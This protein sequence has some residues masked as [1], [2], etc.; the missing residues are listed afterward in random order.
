MQVEFG[1]PATP[2]PIPVRHVTATA[3]RLPGAAWV[4][5]SLI[6]SNSTSD[7][8]FNHRSFEMDRL[9]ARIREELQKRGAE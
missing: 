8:C 5:S 1:E 2:L 9:I 3:F 7:V 4:D 6:R